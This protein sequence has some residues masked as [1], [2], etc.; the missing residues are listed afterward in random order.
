MVTHSA[1]SYKV[2]GLYVGRTSNFSTHGDVCGGR[3]VAVS[4]YEVTFSLRFRVDATLKK[5]L[6]SRMRAGAREREERYSRTSLFF[7]NPYA[8]RCAALSSLEYRLGIVP[9]IS[10]WFGFLVLMYKIVYAF[11]QSS[12]FEVL[13]IYEKRLRDS[14]A[15]TR[16][17]AGSLCRTGTGRS[18]SRSSDVVAF[19]FFSRMVNNDF[20]I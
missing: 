3:T 6:T 14:V 19:R 7:R 13:R 8:R 10:V 12:E 1:H 5:S 15:A 11:W 16:S 9:D 18:V 20:K 4:R 2:A 17:I